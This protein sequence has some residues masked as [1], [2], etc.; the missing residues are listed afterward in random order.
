MKDYFYDERDEIIRPLKTVKK[1][2]VKKS[3]HKH[4][5]V[6]TLQKT[7]TPDIIIYQCSICGKQTER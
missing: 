2:R 1:E 6:A 4:E 7:Y 5:Y 3:N